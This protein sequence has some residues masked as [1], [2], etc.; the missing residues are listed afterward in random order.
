MLVIDPLFPWFGFPWQ[1]ITDLPKVGWLLAAKIFV[2]VISLN[3]QFRVCEI[4]FEFRENEIEIWAKICNFAI[5]EIK[6]WATF[7]QFSKK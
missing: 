4:S 5:H 6:I 7:W 2:F 1:S 3:F